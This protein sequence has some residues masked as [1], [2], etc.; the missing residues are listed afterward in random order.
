MHIWRKHDRGKTTNFCST[1]GRP[2]VLSCFPGWTSG[3]P[4]GPPYLFIVICCH[5]MLSSFAV[6]IRPDRYGRISNVLVPSLV[7]CGVLRRTCLLSADLQQ[8]KFIRQYTVTRE[9]I[10]FLHL[11]IPERGLGGI[12]A[13]SPYQGPS[14]CFHGVLRFSS[15][16]EEVKPLSCT[17][18]H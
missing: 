3:P 17:Y 7:R 15:F 12:P 4:P 8:T 1:M 13:R 6:S 5:A 2:F 11:S 10:H 18:V 16:I 9:N 14:D